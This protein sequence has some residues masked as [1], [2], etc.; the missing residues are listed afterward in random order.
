MKHPGKASMQTGRADIDK[1]R[2]L[3]L[4]VQRGGF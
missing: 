1:L 3:D 2:C 4:L